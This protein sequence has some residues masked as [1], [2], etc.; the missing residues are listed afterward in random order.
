MT[1][2]VRWRES[3]EYLAG[4][5]VN[6]LV[7]VGSGKVLSGLAKRITKEATALSIGTPDDIAAFKTQKGA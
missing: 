6:R 5:G 1:G 4:H 7:E 3:V 2:T